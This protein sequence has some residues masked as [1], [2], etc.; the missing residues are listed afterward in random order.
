MLLVRTIAKF[1]MS[2]V[3]DALKANLL[4]KKVLPPPLKKKKEKKKIHYK[5]G[6]S[7]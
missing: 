2:K 1:F 5:S 3:L 4:V 6:F 7:L